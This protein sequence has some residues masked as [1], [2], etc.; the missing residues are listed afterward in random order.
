MSQKRRTNT[1]KD[2]R[3]WWG[4]YPLAS[5]ERL[6]VGLGALRAAVFCLGEEWQVF[7]ETG[8]EPEATAGLRLQTLAGAPVAERYS[9]AERFLFKHA[10][11]RLHLRPRLADRPVVS[12]PVMPFQLAPGEETIIFVSSPVWLQ[13]EAAE[14]RTP[15][16]ELPGQRLSD[17]W[18][19]PSTQEGELCYATATS[20]RRFLHELPARPHRAVTPVQINN[21]GDT[22]LRLDRISLPTPFLSLYGDAQGALWTQAITLLREEG[23]ELATLK[24]EASAPQEASAAVLVSEPRRTAGKSI[25]VRAFGALFD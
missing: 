19:G 18:F 24:M 8:A 16:L 3:P 20:A 5:G 23:A 9:A 10:R 22:P 14:P 4:D 7:S 2:N 1:D 25:L 15:L 11:E 21:Q 13:L 17:T 12:R 6:E